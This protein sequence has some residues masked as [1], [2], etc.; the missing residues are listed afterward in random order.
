MGSRKSATSNNKLTSDECNVL[1]LADSHG[2]KLA[3]ILRDVNMDLNA[4]GIVK[5]GARTAN[6]IEDASEI[7]TSVKNSDFVVCITGAND[8][9]H[10][11]AAKCIT[12]L[13][14]FL[15]TNKSKNSLVMTIPQRHDLIVNSCVNKE[16]RKT[17]IKIKQ[18]CSTYANCSVVDASKLGRNQ[19]TQHVQHL[20]YHGKKFICQEI[21]KIINETRERSK[22]VLNGSPFLEKTTT[23]M[24][25]T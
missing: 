14:N 12:G 5:P 10:N 24:K 9:A 19:H 1:F 7:K 2:R 21:N 16:I 4:T 20:N 25:K 23:Q 11:E 22:V 13:R 17:N 8:V 15:D 3:S 18:L 6:I